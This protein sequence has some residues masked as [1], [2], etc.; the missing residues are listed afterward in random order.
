MLRPFSLK[1]NN[2]CEI[3]FQS[4]QILFASYRDTFVNVFNLIHLV[5]WRNTFQNFDLC[6]ELSINGVR[7]PEFYATTIQ[8]QV[9]GEVVVGG[10]QTDITF[11]KNIKKLDVVQIC[12]IL[13]IRLSHEDGSANRHYIC[14]KY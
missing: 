1:W 6:N 4:G 14:E 5:I 11:V 2:L 12:K 8:S 9:E 13:M 7:M 10:L 3:H